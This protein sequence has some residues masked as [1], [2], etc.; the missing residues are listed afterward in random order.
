MSEPHVTGTLHDQHGRMIQVGADGG[1][2]TV[3][4]PAGRCTLPPDRA[5]DF[6]RLVVAACWD[7]AAQRSTDMTDAQRAELA[8]AAEEMCLAGCGKVHDETCKGAA[9]GG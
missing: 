6:A 2:V 4:M 7:A 8:A 5:E 9:A 1:S 3:F